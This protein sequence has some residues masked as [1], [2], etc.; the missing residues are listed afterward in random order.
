MVM[1]QE[2]TEGCFV[3]LNDNV[4]N[5][6]LNIDLWRK[7]EVALDWWL[8]SCNDCTYQNIKRPHLPER[9]L[10]DWSLASSAARAD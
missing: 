5:H 2:P 9:D 6:T 1:L 10:R 8:N 3:N 7:L 4:D